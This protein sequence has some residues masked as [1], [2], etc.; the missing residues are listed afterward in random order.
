MTFPKSILGIAAATALGLGLLAAGP[1]SASSVTATGT[2]IATPNGEVGLP[3]VITVKAPRSQFNKVITLTFSTPGVATNAG[4]VTVSPQGFAN[5]TWTPPA[6]GQWTITTTGLPAATASTTISVAPMSTSIVL[7]APNQAGIGVATP[8]LVEVSARGG[9]IAPSGTITVRNQ[10]AQ[11][12]ATGTLTTTQ[13]VT[14]S[15]QLSWTPTAGTTSLT[16]TFNPASGAFSA[17]VSAPE[18]PVI[19]TEPIVA[20]R[21]PPVLYQGVPVTLQAVQSSII[22]AGWGA[23][24]AFNI[25]RDGFLIFGS[26]SQPVVNGVASFVWT[27]PQTGVYT[28]QA[29]YSTGNFVYNGNTSQSVN[30]QPPPTND[31]ITVTANNGPMP[32]T[33][34]A[35]TSVTLGGGA[36]SG[37]AVVFSATG[38]CVVNANVLTALSA[39]SCAVSAYSAGG[40]TLQPVTT[41]NTITVTPAPKKPRPKKR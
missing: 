9:V 30:V 23:S 20:L 2:F 11:V 24:N 21:F 41:T 19:S 25:Y 3:Q 14:S 7:D 33:L 4:Q 15:A 10:T 37:A 32:A 27:P 26:G 1:A 17:S 38:P 28:I 34:Q 18:T 29:E 35:G 8:L 22:P 5:L 39:G 16:A 36:T 12:V 31:T 13:G 40:G 6:A